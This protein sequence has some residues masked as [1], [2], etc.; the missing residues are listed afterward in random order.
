MDDLSPN[1]TLEGPRMAPKCVSDFEGSPNVAY[2]LCAHSLIARSHRD[3]A[4]LIAAMHKSLKLQQF[5]KMQRGLG[6][7]QIL[8]TVVTAFLLNNPL[9]R[10]APASGEITKPTEL[11][12]PIV[13]SDNCFKPGRF[14]GVK[15]LHKTSQQDCHLAV[16]LWRQAHNPYPGHPEKAITFARDPSAHAG[17]VINYKAPF[18]VPYGH[19]RVQ[20][21]LKS[22]DKDLVAFASFGNTM[23]LLDDLVDVCVS[24]K[25]GGFG[26]S[27]AMA[28]RLLASVWGQTVRSEPLQFET[29]LLNATGNLAE[30]DFSPHS[31]QLDVLPTQIE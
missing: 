6:M 29:K 24:P 26:G 27:S 1:E 18:S 19:C 15:H 10:A 2:C 14:P 13:S 16:E 22:E 31:D 17:L 11:T 9:V 3:K 28:P 30:V 23:W 12:P 7:R 8:L 25:F 5:K 4:L 21:D 20:V